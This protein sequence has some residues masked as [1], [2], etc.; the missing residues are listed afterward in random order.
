MTHAYDAIIIGTGQAGPPLAERLTRAGMKVAII[1]RKLC[2]GTC[3]NTGCAPTKHWWRA[4][5]RHIWPVA[6]LILEL[7]LMAGWEWT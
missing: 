6:Q 5:T 4:H 1:E 3:D 2:G 7:R